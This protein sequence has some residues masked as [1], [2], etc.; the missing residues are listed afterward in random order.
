[1][2]FRSSDTT[3]GKIWGSTDIDHMNDSTLGKICGSK[4]QTHEYKQSCTGKTTCQIYVI[5]HYHM[6]ISSCL[7]PLSITAHAGKKKDFH[8]YKIRTYD[9]L[10]LKIPQRICVILDSV[11]HF[12]CVNLCPLHHSW[13][14]TFHQKHNFFEIFHLA[15]KRGMIDF[16]VRGRTKE[17]NR[18]GRIP[19]IKRSCQLVP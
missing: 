4:Y 10:I 19:S 16:F 8:W 3:L 11:L 18:G 7:P 12:L 5:R 6:H 15:T 13:G 9:P 17:F 1:M 14:Y 2:R